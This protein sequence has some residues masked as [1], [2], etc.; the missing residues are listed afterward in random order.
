MKYKGNTKE[1]L[2]AKGIGR[3]LDI[4]YEMQRK[5][6]GKGAR[7]APEIFWF[8]GKCNGGTKENRRAK[9]AWGFSG[10]SKNTKEIQRGNQRAITSPNVIFGNPKF[11]IPNFKKTMGF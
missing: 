1:S 5:Y 6:K 4:S 3:I 9:R 2:R 8:Q 10:F 7:S 11:Q